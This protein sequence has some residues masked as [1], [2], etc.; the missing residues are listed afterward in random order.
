MTDPT[1]RTA[2]NL[3]RGLRE[4]L[5][6]PQS[7]TIRDAVPDGWEAVVRAGC[8]DWLTTIHLTSAPDSRGR[9]AYGAVRTS[10]KSNTELL[11]A[12]HVE[13]CRMDAELE[14]DIKCETFV[15]EDCGDCDACDLKAFRL[16]CD[17][18]EPWVTMDDGCSLHVPTC[19][20]PDTGPPPVKGTPSK[21]GIAAGQGVPPQ[22]EQ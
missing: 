14:H 13:L 18:G 1:P 5:P 8:S 9:V 15:D 20:C 19:R 11:H 16:V 4:T 17:C 6:P 22:R 2:G 3:A 7:G 12:L 10:G 21:A